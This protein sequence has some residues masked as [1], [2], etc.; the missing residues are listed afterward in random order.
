MNKLEEKDNQKIGQLLNM[1][2]SI[3]DNLGYIPEES[4]SK[5]CSSFDLSYAE[6]IGFITFYKDFKLKPTKSRHHIRICQAESCQAR[7]VKPLTDYIKEKL[8][9]EIG[10]YND[11]FFLDSVF[12]LGN[13]VRSPSVMIDGKI[14]G[15][16]D[17]GK[18]DS[19]L[20]DLKVN[21]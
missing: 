5:L 20:N 15:D 14:Y 7:N 4:I 13:C 18:F 17:K 10:E 12:C 6:I 11:N 2:H 9:L 8:K 16:L 3:Q 21:P 1:L 19:L